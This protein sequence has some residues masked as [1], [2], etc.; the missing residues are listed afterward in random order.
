MFGEVM[1]GGKQ[2]VGLREVVMSEARSRKWRVE[3]RAGVGGGGV[4]VVA[5]EVR[6]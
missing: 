2:L 1:F 6:R 5:R 3:I 4:R